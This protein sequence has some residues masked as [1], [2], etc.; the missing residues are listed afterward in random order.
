MCV[1]TITF[2]HFR[3]TNYVMYF[4]FVFSLMLFIPPFHSTFI[5]SHWLYIIFL[6]P[7]PVHVANSELKVLR[8]FFFF[9]PFFSWSVRETRQMNFCAFELPFQPQ[10]LFQ[11]SPQFSFGKGWFSKGNWQTKIYQKIE[12]EIEIYRKVTKSSVVV[13][14]QINL[15][16]SQNKVICN[17]FSKAFE[18]DPWLLKINHNHL[19][20]HKSTTFFPKYF[21]S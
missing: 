8:G 13:N 9:V 14:Q 16:C 18:I 2:H 20:I 4:C 10:K 15:F 17:L 3:L 12:I 21:V 11:L 7:F 19:E 5:I 6:Q 1:I